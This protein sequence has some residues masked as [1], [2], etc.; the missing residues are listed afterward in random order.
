[1]AITNGTSAI[2][3]GN[4]GNGG[5]GGSGGSAGHI[6]IIELNQSS[7]IVTSMNKGKK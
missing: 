3:P 1:M 2:K 5:D 7:Q 4:G 6:K